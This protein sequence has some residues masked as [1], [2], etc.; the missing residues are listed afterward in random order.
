MLDINRTDRL[1]DLD[2]IGR[3]GQAAREVAHSRYGWDQLVAQIKPVAL[4]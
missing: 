2:T 4:A 3:I 1:P